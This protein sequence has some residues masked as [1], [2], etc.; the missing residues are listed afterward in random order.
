MEGRMAR[1]SYEIFCGQ[2]NLSTSKLERIRSNKTEKRSHAKCYVVSNLRR[3][4]ASRS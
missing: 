1:S 4:I 2:M 3:R